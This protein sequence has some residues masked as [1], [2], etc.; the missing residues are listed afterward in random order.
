M[1]MLET[2]MVT[3]NITMKG[4]MEGDSQVLSGEEFTVYVHVD[5]SGVYAVMGTLEYDSTQVT[6]ISA[7]SALKEWDLLVQGNVYLAEENN[8][9]QSPLE[10][11]VNV[12][13]FV[14][15]VNEGVGTGTNINI[16]MTDMSSSNGEETHSLQRMGRQISVVDTVTDVPASNTEQTVAKESG[17][18]QAINGMNGKTLD[19]ILGGTILIVVGLAIG[20]G[21]GLIKN[22]NNE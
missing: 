15:R 9:F 21:V 10:A 8:E 16:A 4:S 2:N 5:D 7:T 19:Y 1:I 17:L 11:D 13:K 12:M 6:L 3:S 18:M 20:I 22:K 14:F